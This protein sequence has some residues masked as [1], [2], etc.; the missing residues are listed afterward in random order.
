MKMARVELLAALAVLAHAPVLWVAAALLGGPAM[1]IA[2]VAAGVGALT[3]AAVHFSPPAIGRDAVAAGWMAQIAVAL[4]ALQG[5][6]W[7][8]DLHMY[9]FAA[10]A[11]LV[12]F[13]EVQPILVA[14]GVVAVHHLSVTFLAPQLIYPNGGGIGRVILHAAILGLE[15]VWLVWTI[16]QIKASGASQAR[17]ASVAEAEAARAKEALAKAD[18]VRAEADA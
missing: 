16:L 7:Q 14:A 5:H 15:T 17:L 2:G 12:I 13:R 6:P 3:V 8:T 18:T 4:A 1:L 9:F 11:V 10:L